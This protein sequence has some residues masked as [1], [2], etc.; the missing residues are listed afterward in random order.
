VL[1]P[2]QASVL[3]A[4]GMLAADVRRDYVQTI[5]LSGPI[6]SG[7][8]ARRFIPL[9]QQ[10]F[11]DLRREG[12]PRSAMILERVLEVRY[13][14][15][16]YTLSVPFN[17]RWRAAF[18][19]MHRSAYGYADP[20]GAVEITNLRVHATGLSSPP[21]LAEIERGSTEPGN[22]PPCGKRPSW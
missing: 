20:T 19:E 7:E 17:R 2:A 4:L 12:F 8:L 15:Q 5:M 9:L 6:P 11:R 10:A 22:E 18:E 1:V 21:R 3:S 14:G 13:A 16:S